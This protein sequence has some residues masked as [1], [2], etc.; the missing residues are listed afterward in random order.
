M[1][2]RLGETNFKIDNSCNTWK[3]ATPC[4]IKCRTRGVVLIVSN[5]GVVISWRE[6][7]GAESLAQVALLFLDTLDLLTGNY[8]TYNSRFH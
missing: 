8:I 1:R 3:A 4:E 6:I 5:C 7:Y 2:S